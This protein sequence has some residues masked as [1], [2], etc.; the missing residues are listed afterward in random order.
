MDWIVKWAT[1]INLTNSNDRN[2]RINDL[3]FGTNSGGNL[4][5]S[6]PQPFYRVIDSKLLRTKTQYFYLKIVFL[7]WMLFFILR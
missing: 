7:S 2:I 5:S 3:K 1:R 6:M 4:I